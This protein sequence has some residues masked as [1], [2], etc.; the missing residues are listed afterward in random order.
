MGVA[1]HGSRQIWESPNMGVAKYKIRQTWESPNMGV[2][3]RRDHV[4]EVNLYVLACDGLLLPQ[5]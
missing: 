4:D 5:L 3:G 2:I 1:K